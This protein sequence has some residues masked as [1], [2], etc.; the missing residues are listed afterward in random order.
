[1]SEFMQRQIVKSDWYEVDGNLG[2]EVFPS[3]VCSSKRDARNLYSG[4]RVDEVTFRKGWYGARLSAPG[5]MDC[6]EWTVFDSEE[7]A[8]QYLAENYPDTSEGE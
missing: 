4:A 7:A 3:D 6:T 8:R 5:Y 2:T 1:M